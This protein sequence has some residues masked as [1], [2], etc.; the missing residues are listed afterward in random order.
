M[1]RTVHFKVYQII[2][3][4]QLFFLNSTISYT[5][6]TLPYIPTEST[7]IFNTQSNIND[8]GLKG[9][10]R[11]I[12]TYKDSTLLSVNTFSKKGNLLKE[13][14]SSTEKKNEFQLKHYFY[15]KRQLLKVKHYE[16][17]KKRK[18]K[19]ITKI[20]YNND[21]LK[22][23][24]FES[25]NTNESFSENYSYNK[26]GLIK[27]KEFQ[28]KGHLIK[29]ISQYSY[30]KHKKIS[31]I[32]DLKC[33]ENEQ[34]DSINYQILAYNKN[35]QLIEH[36]RYKKKYNKKGVSSYDHSAIF[37][38]YNQEGLLYHFKDGNSDRYFKYNKERY[39]IKFSKKGWGRGKTI[40]YQY[41]KYNN[42]IKEQ[43]I[44][45]YSPIEKEGAI[46]ELPPNAKIFRLTPRKSQ[47]I[48]KEIEYYEN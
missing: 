21:T 29:Y 44:N 34:C 10:V 32:L 20:Q 2:F 43:I 3:L 7:H 18:L 16:I 46:S 5:Q 30:N 39:L 12:K 22:K 48:I 33:E 14:I 9:K 36:H 11:A 38:K 40:L 41:D 47:F 6:N 24:T 17:I 23:I 8:F 35:G 19:G 13:I 28:K 45:E 4:S 31:F 1:Q 27:E 15:K 25:R 26:D 37:Y 42:L